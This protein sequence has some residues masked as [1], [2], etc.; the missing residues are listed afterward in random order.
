MGRQKVFGF[1]LNLDASSPNANTVSLFVNGARHG[2]PQALPENL[3][4]K[5][6]FPH[7]T[8]RDMT[9]QVQFGPNPFAALPFK[10]R[11]VQSAAKADTQASAFAAPKDGKYDVVYPVGFPDQGTFKWLESFKTKNPQYTELS[12]RAIQKWCVASG[13]KNWHKGYSSNDKPPFHFGVGFIDEPNTFRRSIL[14]AASSVPRHYVVMEVL[15]NL[16]AERR[17]FNLKRFKAAHFKQIAHVVMGE[18]DKEFK[19]GVHA[20]LLKRK[21]ASAD[22]EWRR[23]KADQE[24]RKQAIQKKKEMEEKR[25]AVQEEAKKRREAVEAKRKEKEAEAKKKKE[26]EAAKKKEE[27]KESEEKKEEEKKPKKEE[28]AKEEKDVEMKTEEKKEEPKKEEET[29]EEEK[30]E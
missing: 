27:G 20:E 10:A 9:L 3:Q 6:L 21:Q 13:M 29:K 23:K 12:D 16:V 25:K 15:D 30:K 26:E 7:V 5:A 14:L 4:G 28:E 1:L 24:R 19:Q 8:F 17:A 18:P 22:G 11:M 2:A